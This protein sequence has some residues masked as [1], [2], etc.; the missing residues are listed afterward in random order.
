[1][2]PH[3]RGSRTQ[4]PHTTITHV[5]DANHPYASTDPREIQDPRTVQEYRTRRG[6]KVQ[7]TIPGVSVTSSGKVESLSTR[8]NC[9]SLGPSPLLEVHHCDS[10][11]AGASA[12][13]LNY[14]SWQSPPPSPTTPLIVTRELTA[15]LSSPTSIATQTSSARTVELSFFYDPDLDGIANTSDPQLQNLL[16][17]IAG[18][19]ESFSSEI[20]VPAESDVRLAVEG[21][22]PTGKKLTTATFEEPLNPVGLPEFSYK[23]GADKMSIGLADGSAT[24]PIN[25]YNIPFDKYEY[26][27]S[28]PDLWWEN[29]RKYYPSGWAYEP[30][31]FY[32]GYR[33]P[34]GRLAGTPHLGLDI[35][36]RDGSPVHACWGGTIVEALYDWKFGIDSGT[37]IAYY[38]HL[39]PTVKIGDRVSRYDRL[40]AVTERLGHVHF[41]LRPNPEEVLGI[42]TTLSTEDILK[43]PLRGERAPH[44]PYFG[45]F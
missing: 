17:K 43:S 34:E 20:S 32:Y 42:F 19:Q 28:H 27:R 37:R 36:A 13:G 22:S 38:N 8:L 30:N 45:P 44:L 14:F 7:G 2:E 9:D 4:P 16:I 39:D 35:W 25:P 5:P 24:S 33:I 11:V 6:R 31:Y 15:T 10:A 1:M 21:L 18:Q 41:E 26:A 29:A 12:L 3:P 23:T 40:G